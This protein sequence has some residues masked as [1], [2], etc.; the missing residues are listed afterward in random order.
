MKYKEFKKLSEQFQLGSLTTEKFH[1][2]T[3]NLSH[4]SVNN[5]SQALS[6]LSEIDRDTFALLDRKKAELYGVYNR[7]SSIKASGA[8]IY[9]CGCGATGRLSLAIETIA[10][11]LGIKTIKSFMAGGDYALIK[12][13]ESFEDQIDYGK[14]QLQD[15]GFT[16]DDLLIAITEGG[17][18]SFVIGAALSACEISNHKPIFMYCNPDQELAHLERCNRVLNN[19]KIQKLNLTIGAMALSGS[20]R[21]QASS[22]QMYISG[23]ICLKDFSSFESFSLYIKNSIKVFNSLNYSK[24][25]AFIESESSSYKQGDIVTYKSSQNLAIS[26]LTDTTERSPTFNLTPFENDIHNELSLCYLAVENTTSSEVAWLKMLGREPRFLDW[27]IDYERINLSQIYAFDISENCLNRRSIQ[28]SKQNNTDK[29]NHIFSIN[30][31]KEGFSF[32]FRDSNESF[33]I[34]TEDPLL[35]H[36]SLKV[37][38]NAHST[39]VMGRLDRYQSNI[40]TWVKPSNYKLIDRATRYAQRLLE[41]K[42]CKIQYDVILEYI[43]KSTSSIDPEESIVLEAVKRFS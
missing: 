24:L 35:K 4:D 39:L 16:K 38:L 34:K 5:L 9:L 40:M 17:E 20:T 6:L 1:T 8:S 18:T 22:I 32:L 10:L 28:H 29:K 21:M 11:Q 25:Q 23:L 41:L 27:G 26:V 42:G 36:I 3:K 33:N 31:N 2:K 37:L 43:F 14:R 7:V 12:S 15:L 30:N 19:N 13:V